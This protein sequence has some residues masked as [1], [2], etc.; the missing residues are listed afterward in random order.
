MVPGQGEN[1]SLCIGDDEASVVSRAGENDS[2]FNGVLC[3]SYGA[4]N[5]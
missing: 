5:R 4:G 2:V 3:R 1:S